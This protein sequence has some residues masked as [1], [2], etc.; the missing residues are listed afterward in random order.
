LFVQVDRD[1]DLLT[2][3]F[4]FSFLLVLV[5]PL[6]VSSG[7]RRGQFLREF[8]SLFIRVV[9]GSFNEHFTDDEALL[10]VS[11]LLLIEI[12]LVLKLEVIKGPTVVLGNSLSCGCQEGFGV[13]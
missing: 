4:F 13:E 8:D 1:Q 3:V 2:E 6:Q 7:K 12:Q 11:E 9:L 10:V 5:D